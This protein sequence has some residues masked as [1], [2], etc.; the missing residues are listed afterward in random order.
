MARRKNHPETVKTK[1]H[2]AERLREVRVELFGERGGSEMARRLSVPIRTWYNYEAGVTVPAEVLLRFIELT[3]IEPTWLL[4]GRGPRY[5]TPPVDSRAPDPAMSVESLLRT[6]LQKL[7]GHAAP[8]AGAT[9]VATL[10]RLAGDNGEADG[11]PEP[12]ESTKEW[13]AAEREGRCVRVEGD[14]MTPVLASG[15]RVAFAAED[16]PVDQLHGSLVVAWIQGRPVVRWFQRSGEFGL[17]HAENPDHSPNLLL[18]DLN[19]P[20]H[21]RRIRRV[22][23]TR[24]PH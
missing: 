16:E 13:L 21:E 7:E 12:I 5:R 18:V 2:L 4:H 6:A 24:T 20:L 1:C 22:L 14:A 19:G 10:P 23:W 3:S 9:A 11:E 8:A 15:A 17:L